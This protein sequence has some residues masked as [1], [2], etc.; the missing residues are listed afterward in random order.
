MVRDGSRSPR[1]RSASARLTKARSSRD[2]LR[3]ATGTRSRE[4][5]SRSSA[6]GRKRSSRGE[7]DLAVGVGAMHIE[8]KQDRGRA[9]PAAHV[10]SER[11]NEHGTLASAAASAAAGELT[12]PSAREGRTSLAIEDRPNPRGF[13]YHT[14]ADSRPLRGEIREAP[15]ALPAEP[16][17]PRPEKE[18]APR[19]RSTSRGRKGRRDAAIPEFIESDV[20]RG[21]PRAAHGVRSAS[22][23]LREDSRLVVAGGM[24][25]SGSAVSLGTTV[26]SIPMD[27]TSSS[28]AI[29]AS[30]ST[31]SKS[32]ARSRSPLPLENVQRVA[33]QR[34]PVQPDFKAR[35]ARYALPSG[36]TPVRESCTPCV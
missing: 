2:A 11:G 14:G 15:A 34:T 8:E 22:E 1:G 36:D 19:R 32:K 30:L 31:S 3:E 26:S 27:D 5:T 29:V 28:W 13:V 24:P 10:A 18:Y 16:P 35:C 9:Q 17:E 25:R 12:Q 20:T 23:S 4:D 21:L 7:V 6:R 33:E